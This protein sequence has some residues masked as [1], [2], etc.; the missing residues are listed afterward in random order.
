MRARI[1]KVIDD[2]L[3]IRLPGP[4]MMLTSAEVGRLLRVSHWTLQE[5]RKAGRGPRF[6]KLT[7][8]VVRYPLLEF[9]LWLGEHLRSTV[10]SGEENRR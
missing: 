1:R 6:V 3:E 4:P 10:K 9:G 2:R 8:A 5:W 7:H